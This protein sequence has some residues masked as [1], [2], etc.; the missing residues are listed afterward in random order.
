M[1]TVIFGG[2][3]NT[4]ARPPRGSGGLQIGG[5]PSGTGGGGIDRRGGGGAS[6]ADQA[7]DVRSGGTAG[8]G[9]SGRFDRAGSGGG[10][11]AMPSPFV[12]GQFGRERD[13]PGQRRFER[14]AV[15]MIQ[16]LRK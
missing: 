3:P 13:W 8:G 15:V 7:R 16:R 6:Y 9:G 14:A 1:L 2:V 5:A 12:R 11:K 4:S 10:S